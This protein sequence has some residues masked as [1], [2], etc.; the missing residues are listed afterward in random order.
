MKY[1]M[2]A[3]DL[4][5]TLFDSRGRIPEAN[6]EAIARARD[7][8]LLVVPCTGRALKEAQWALEELG[9]DTPAVL[10]GGAHVSDPTTGQTLYRVTVE[11]NL[12]LDVVRSLRESGHAVLILLDPEITGDDY[13][14]VDDD[15]LTPNT[16]W[17]FESIGARV[18][19]LAEPT[20]ADLHHALRVGIVGE[21]DAMPD[22]QTMLTDRF[23]EHVFVQHF[24]A[25]GDHNERINVLEVF[26][27]GVNKWSGLH[28]VAES[29]GFDAAEVAAIGDEINDLAMIESAGCG[30]A[31]G[32]A[33]P[34]V[35]DVARRVTRSNDEG[36]VAH[37]IKHLLDG[38]W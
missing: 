36:G 26:A 13:L 14:V 16:R 34:A 7:D 3:I 11:P 5:G 24:Q 20:E 8:G 37:A 15:R 31:M 22:V 21:S 35:R 9:H 19:P 29:H 27:K 33:I 28:W 32:N 17:W 10:A 25:V 4:D 12:A 30:I 38:R 2:L 18:K 6:R 23:A 1:R